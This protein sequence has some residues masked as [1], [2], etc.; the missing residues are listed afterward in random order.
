MCWRRYWQERP[1]WAE[2]EVLD[3]WLW[4]Q[5]HLSRESAHN[6]HFLNT[7]NNEQVVLWSRFCFW[8]TRRWNATVNVAEVVCVKD[9]PH[10]RKSLFPF[11]WL[12][13]L[14][15]LCA[16]MLCSLSNRVAKLNNRLQNFSFKCKITMSLMGSVLNRSVSSLGKKLSLLS[17]YNVAI[18]F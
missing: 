18:W 16:V 4:K 13:Q 10:D 2:L 3:W 14:G 9:I 7:W 6:F 17:N 8:R 1:I 11:G 15:R 5:Q 12:R